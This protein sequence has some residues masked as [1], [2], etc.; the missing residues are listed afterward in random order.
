L[1]CSRRRR[2]SSS[3]SIEGHLKHRYE[4]IKCD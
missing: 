1:I 3:S 4:R 2:E